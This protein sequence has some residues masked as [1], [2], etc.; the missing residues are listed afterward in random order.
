VPRRGRRRPELAQEK[1][2]VKTELGE[3]FGSH[4]DARRWLSETIEVSYN[5]T[6]RHSAIG[7]QGPK[8]LERLA[9]R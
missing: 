9:A 2:T 5:G 6:W 7:H 4:S 1:K 3:R 8:E